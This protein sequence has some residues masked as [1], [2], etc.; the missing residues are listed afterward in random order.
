LNARQK[1]QSCQSYTSGVEPCAL[2]FLTHYTGDIHQPLH[3]SYAVDAG[4]NGY[5]VTYFGKSTN[6]HSVWDTSMIATW[7]NGDSWQLKA[8]EL[9]LQLKENPNLLKAYQNVT[10]VQ[11]WANESF[12]HTRFSCYNN[13]PGTA[14]PVRNF[15]EEHN[16]TPISVAQAASQ[17]LISTAEHTEEEHHC[18]REVPLGLFTAT[19]CQASL[20]TVYYERN[21]P[22]ITQRLGMAG[23]RLANLLNSI[24]DP[25]STAHATLVDSNWRLRLLIEQAA[26]QL[27]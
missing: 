10:D 22:I 6:L 11:K 4:G 25:D 20:D 8:D 15:D 1:T 3:V 13:Q 23:A 27:Q 17:T 18:E 24:Y 12:F 2:S 21:I 14:S 5:S 16:V 26:K 7:E 19:S 9:I